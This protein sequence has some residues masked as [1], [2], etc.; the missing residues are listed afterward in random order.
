MQKV[1]SKQLAA[2]EIREVLRRPSRVR[3][4]VWGTG[5]SAWN[6]GCVSLYIYVYMY[7]Y[8]YGPKGFPR[9]PLG[10]LADLI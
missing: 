9:V 5:G 7:I 6:F 3:V 4:R 8:I 1:P 2:R 10:D